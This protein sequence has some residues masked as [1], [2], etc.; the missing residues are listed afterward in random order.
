MD[1]ITKLYQNRAKVLQEEVNRLEGLLEAVVDAPPIDLRGQRLQAQAAAAKLEAEEQAKA[2]AAADAEIKK[3]E[4]AVGL[5]DQQKAKLQYDRNLEALGSILPNTFKGGVDLAKLAYDNPKG[6]LAVGAGALAGLVGLDYLTNKIAKAG[7][8]AGTN[9]PGTSKVLQ[10]GW[11]MLPPARIAREK[12]EKAIEAERLAKEAA[13]QVKLAGEMG[14]LDKFGQTLIP[15]IDRE[16]YDP[17]TWIEGRPQGMGAPKETRGIPDKAFAAARRVGG[18]GVALEPETLVRLRNRAY[19]GLPIGDPEV[20]KEAGEGLN[21]LVM[22]GKEVG[23]RS[24]QIAK[25]ALSAASKGL[26]AIDPLSLGAEVITPLL[27]GSEFA[28]GVAMAPL[29][30]GAFTSEAGR[31]SEIV[32]SEEEIKARQDWANEQR[33]QQGLTSVDSISSPT[34]AV[35]AA[36][37]GAVTVSQQDRAKLERQAMGAKT[38]TPNLDRIQ[39]QREML[40]RLQSGPRMFGGGVK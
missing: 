36:S 9:L 15:G 10:T 23:K 5:T 27:A 1:H 32:P 17:N 31:G 18:P 38:S 22:T 3:T 16:A 37:L 4:E 30:I 24:A 21:D 12:A 13:R 34:S 33:K 40:Q 7:A 25:G 20:W 14:E 19:S 29:A 35:D 2:K 6:T 11:E 8:R 28:A 39:K 26:N